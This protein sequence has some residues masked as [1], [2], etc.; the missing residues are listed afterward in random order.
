M[1]YKVI[2]NFL[3]EEK[4]DKVKK[5]INHTNFPWF[6]ESQISKPNLESTNYKFYLTHTCYINSKPN[7]ELYE[8]IGQL[9][10]DELK[11][12]SMLRMKVNFYPNQGSF[13][14]H[15]PHVDYHYPHKGAIF[16][17][18]TCNGYTKLNDGTKIDSIENRMLI[19]DSSLKHC[20]TNT[21]NTNRR[22]NINFNY[23]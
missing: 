2:D 20:S 5:S 6:Y 13:E 18:N 3:D 8:E 22:L 21:T 9:F 15:D 23:F 16:S 1:K 17:L 11:M 7:S 19:F 10:F 12:K 14:E 4:L